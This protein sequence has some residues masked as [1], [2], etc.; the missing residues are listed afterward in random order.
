M[1]ALQE[2]TKAQENKFKHEQDLL[3]KAKVRRNRMLGIWAA[4]LMNL[5]QNDTEKY[6]DA[7]V[8]LHLKDT[9]RQKLCDKILSDFNYAGVHKS[10]HRIERMI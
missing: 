6:A 3:F 10:E 7:F 5:N 2:L 8:E 9:G 4:N 1:D